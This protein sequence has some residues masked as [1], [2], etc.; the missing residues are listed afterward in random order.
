M[1]RDSKK[2][3]DELFVNM[4]KAQADVVKIKPTCC[5]EI[6]YKMRKGVSD[7]IETI[8]SHYTA[9]GTIAHIKDKRDGQEYIV[10]IKPIKRK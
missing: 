8:D 2:V 7:F 1:D 4:M 5:A 9:H 3:F 6:S 10:E